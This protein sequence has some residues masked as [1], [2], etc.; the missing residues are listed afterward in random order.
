ML[1]GRFHEIGIATPDIRASVEFYE[2]LGFT[3]ATTT[4]TWS[5]PYGVLTDGRIFLGLHQRPPSQAGD[6]TLT[7]VHPDLASHL[8]ELERRGVELITRNIGNH[9]FNQIDFLDPSGQRVSVI[10]AR[11]YSPV[12]RSPAQSSL[13]GYFAELSLPARSFSEAQAF[14]EPLGFVAVEHAHDPYEHLSLTSDHLDIAFH[15]PRTFSQPLLV[16][17]DDKMPERITRLQQSNL[18]PS[19]DLPRGVAPSSS[20]VVRAPEGTALLLVEDALL[21]AKP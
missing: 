14:W 16:F 7:F 12:A 3:Q 18:P 15:H 17:C 8:P 1:L 19:N 20:A 21:S 10:E 6:L 9:V 13:C 11:T 2:S 4:D 5:H